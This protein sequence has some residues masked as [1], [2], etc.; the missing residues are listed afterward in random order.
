MKQTLKTIQD[1]LFSLFLLALMLL[2]TSGAVV[3]AEW[4]GGLSVLIP[5][6]LIAMTL[7]YLLAI[8]SFS[9]ALIS[10]FS[11]FYGA[12]LVW[13]FVSH[14]LPQQMTARQRYLELWH[15]LSIWVEQA[16][17]GGFSRDNL[18]FLLLLAIVYWFIG[19]NA[20]ANTFRTKR[21]WLAVI[22]PGLALLINMYYY[23]GPVRMDVLLIVYLFLTFT[24]AVRANA[25]YREQMWRRKRV[26]FTPGIRFDLLRGG[27]IAG[28]ILIAIAWS[29]PAASA[30]NRLSSAWDRSVNPWH[31]VQDTFNR[32]FGG[33]E[34]GSAVTADYYGGAFLSLGGPVNLGNSTVMYVYAPE[35]HHYYWRSKVFDRYDNGRWVS[36]SDLRIQSDFGV[37]NTEEDLIYALR[38]NV[39]QRFEFAIPATRLVYAAPQP[40]SFASLPVSIDL[41]YTTPGR[42]FAVISTVRAQDVIRAGDGYSATSSISVADEA[43][44]RAAGTDYPDWVR[45]KFLVVPVSITERTRDLAAEI[46][47]GQE[48][49]YDV[50]HAVES[51]LRQNITYNEQVA[52]PPRGAEPVDYVLFE[53]QEGYCNYYASAMVIML[54]SQGIPARVAAGFVQGD[55]DPQLGAYRVLESDAHAWVEVYFPGYGWIEFEPTAAETPVIRPAESSPDLS[56]MEL[57]ERDPQVPDAGDFLDEQNPD[58]QQPDGG[59]GA[60]QPT[61]LLGRLR[62]FRL[63]RLAWW[64]LGLLGVI[65][66]GLV[67]G[68]FWIEQ[69]G[70]AGQ[71]EV[72]RSYA[73]LNIYAPWVGAQPDPAE[74]P[75]ERGEGIAARLP[76]GHDLVRR[77]TALYVEEQYA[78]APELE[79]HRD[80]ANTLAQEAWQGLR[81]IF[82]KTG[83]LRWLRARVPFLKEE[84][85]ND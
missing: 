26:T 80:K 35:G 44:L 83:L 48:T 19:F 77:I 4:V 34:G 43:S 20:A 10:L 38:T 54:R 27:V 29:A 53:S 49:P 37:L 58:A 78:P 15:R 23:L 1:D 63:P 82:I 72:S 69:R 79:M 70:L 6:T 47:S 51:Y 42:D 8:S 57:L 12:P 30:S 9:D 65:G 66:A 39:Q 56:D 61:T 76:G 7:A 11:L 55:F 45:E 85:P 40:V 31:R 81:G 18:I 2:I 16:A 33:V 5:L 28:V 67:G 71:S 46:A 52:A 68:W 62:A 73:R 25:V 32:L 41:S 24:L 50:A 13:M 74:T 64:G 22:P 75:F 36:T 21:V 60:D 14:T 59:L 84:P 3:L 17:E